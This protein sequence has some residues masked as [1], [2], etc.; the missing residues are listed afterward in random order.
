MVQP[1]NVAQ[2]AQASCA[3][4]TGYIIQTRDGED[5]GVRDEIIPVHTEELPLTSHVKCLKSARA[6]Q[7]MPW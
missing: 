2:Q 1:L 7:S 6:C 3:D 4:D 5:E